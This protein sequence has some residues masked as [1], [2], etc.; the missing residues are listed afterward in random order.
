MHFNI[1]IIIIV[2]KLLYNIFIIIWFFFFFEIES[3]N[4]KKQQIT[5]IM[6]TFHE[7][8]KSVIYIQEMKIVY[9]L[10]TALKT[11]IFKICGML[12]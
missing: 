12:I 3:S 10:S 11:Q 2:I 6:I 7:F 1:I 5:L 4:T 9:V 8:F